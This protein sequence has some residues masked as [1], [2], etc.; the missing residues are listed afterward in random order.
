MGVQDHTAET[1]CYLLLQ[2]ILPQVVFRAHVEVSKSIGTSLIAVTHSLN[3]VLS[4][5]MVYSTP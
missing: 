1:L 5:I 2:C 3:V 4:F